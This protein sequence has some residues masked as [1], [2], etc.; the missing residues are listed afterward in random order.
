MKEQDKT[1]EKHLN[2]TN[3]N[4]L[5]DSEFKIMVTQML[6][7]LGR[8]MDKHSGNVNRETEN[9]RKFQIYATELKNAI[10]K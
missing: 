1:L 9:V 4:K 2:E 3:T 5:L 6:S 10:T 7:K 8:K